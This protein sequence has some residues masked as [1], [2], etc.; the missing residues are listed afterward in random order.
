MARI[1][2]VDPQAAAADIILPAVEHLPGMNEVAVLDALSIAR[3]AGKYDVVVAGPGLDTMA[4]LKA[5][6]AL[7]EADPAVSIVLAFDRR[8]RVSLDA[9][10]RA[11]AVDLLT[12]EA[13]AATAVKALTRAIKIADGRRAAATANAAPT[14]GTVITVASASGGCG[15][16]F[17]AVNA[18]Y[19]FMKATGGRAC[20]VDLDLQFGEVSTALRLQP[21]LTLFDAH[22]RDQAGEA[23]L[24]DH[25]D[26]YLVEHPTGICVLP[27][28]RDP[29]EADRVD[30]QD[31]L[32]I[33]EAARSRFD[34]VVVD[35]PAAL[36]ECVLAALDVSELLYVMTT[37]DVPS[38]RNLGVFLN[39]LTRLK[40]PSESIRLVMNKAESGVGMQVDEV[41]RLFPGGFN[42]VLP[43]ASVVSRSLN[44]GTPVLAAFPNTEVS[45]K[46][47]AALDAVVPADRRRT[48][49]TTVEGPAR[50]AGVFGR[51]FAFGGAR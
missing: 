47:A 32:R 24:E 37:L 44:Q 22:E 17:F 40:V 34:Y 42:A 20:I 27:A 39:T 21:A 25:L 12:T 6:A 51:I 36:S 16:T 35:T 45:R 13:T 31:V 30:P 8:P 1:L 41:A 46:L 26:D 10:V 4:G 3:D 38:V 14:R 28:P 43:Y 5:L 50:R 18:A 9:V 2:V 23:R 48:A 11:G 33:V 19:H 15:K 7:Q 49:T 29:S